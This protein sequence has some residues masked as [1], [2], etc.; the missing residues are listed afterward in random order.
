MRKKI[1]TSSSG[2][3]RPIV[4]KSNFTTNKIMKV[5]A[6]LAALLIAA[7]VLANDYDRR[8]R[9]NQSNRDSGACSIG[10]GCK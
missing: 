9:N 4:T 2:Y 7:P 10:Y 6:I 5:F 8:P 1:S 3:I